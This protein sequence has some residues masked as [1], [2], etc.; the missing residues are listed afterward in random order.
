MDKE[1]CVSNGVIKAIREIFTNHSVNTVEYCADMYDRCMS[2][3]F[4]VWEDGL[5]IWRV[6]IATIV[7]KSGYALGKRK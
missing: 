3:L 4:T 1:A 2:P 7:S 5:L 6:V